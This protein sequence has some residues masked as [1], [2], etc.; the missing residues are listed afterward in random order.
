MYKPE[1]HKEREEKMKQLN[2]KIADQNL[3][4][5]SKSCSSFKT[6]SFD[7]NDNM[8]QKWKFYLNYVYF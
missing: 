4:N 3:D 7:E 8:R 2:Q 1:E 5:E 6:E